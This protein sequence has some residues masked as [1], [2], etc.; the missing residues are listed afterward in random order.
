MTDQAPAYAQAVD[1]L[2]AR[3][4]AAEKDR[5]MY[6]RLSNDETEAKVAFRGERDA[7]VA[8][9]EAAE[10]ERAQAID[11]LYALGRYYGRPRAA[12][13]TVESWS[14]RVTKAIHANQE[15][16]EVSV[17]LRE[18]LDQLQG[19]NSRLKAEGLAAIERA[20]AAE[21]Q[22]VDA[23][24]RAD[25]A[26]KERDALRAQIQNGDYLLRPAPPTISEVM[27]QGALGR[28]ESAEQERDAIKAAAVAQLEAVTAERDEYRAQLNRAAAD[29]AQ[30]RSENTR[31]TAENA[32]LAQ[33]LS[34]NW[35]EREVDA[36]V[37]ADFKER[38]GPTAFERNQLRAKLAAA[39]Q[40]AT[41]YGNDAE[42][43]Q[44]R[45]NTLTAA[46]H[47]FISAIARG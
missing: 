39:E 28:A 27:L 37:M 10:K 17:Q 31:L 1:Q 46:C 15:P 38:T 44:A 40:K 14:G 41:E 42:Q 9:A 45:L 23:A 20:K 19:V 21:R 24:A 32:D 33:K 18:E 13:E 8:R 22:H 30:I 35:I 12:D 4:E 25:A 36:R 11:Y 26:E 47:A 34:G 5:D 2:R 43:T 29:F 3:A 7:A 6:L 16:S